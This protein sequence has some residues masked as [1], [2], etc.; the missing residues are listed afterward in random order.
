MSANLFPCPS[1]SRHRIMVMARRSL[2]EILTA[3]EAEILRLVGII[4]KPSLSKFRTMGTID[5]A[6]HPRGVHQYVRGDKTLLILSERLK[7][8]ADFI[9]K[10]SGTD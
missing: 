7:R 5:P 4:S 10:H 8:V 1:A 2:D 3:I 9:E 6:D